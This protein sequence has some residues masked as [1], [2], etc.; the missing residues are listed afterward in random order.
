MEMSRPYSD[1]QGVEEI[2]IATDGDVDM[3]FGKGTEEAACRHGVPRAF[4]REDRAREYQY[5]R[6][7]GPISLHGER[8]RPDA[9]AG[10]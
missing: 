7:D 6:H 2:W 1:A 10:H 8:H 5:V 9:S 4:N 3:L